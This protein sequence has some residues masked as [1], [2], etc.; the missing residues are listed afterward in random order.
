MAGGRLLTEHQQNQTRPH[1]YAQSNNGMLMNHSDFTATAWRKSKTLS[2]SS[3]MAAN[4]SALSLAISLLLLS[5]SPP[6]RET[7]SSYSSAKL[8]ASSSS[9]FETMQILNTSRR[10]ASAVSSS[11]IAASIRNSSR[12]KAFSATQSFCFFDLERFLTAGRRST[13]AKGI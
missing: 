13:L 8:Y 1:V 9:P 5:V 11:R 10:L 4:V 6:S 7:L 3:T 2:Q 12:S